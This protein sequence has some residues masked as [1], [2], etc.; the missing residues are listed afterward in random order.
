MCQ[1]YQFSIT[2]N[3]S[4][5]EYFIELNNDLS[6]TFERKLKQIQQ[7]AILVA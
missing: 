4:Q 1:K 3:Y 6:L 7:Q 2:A 5:L